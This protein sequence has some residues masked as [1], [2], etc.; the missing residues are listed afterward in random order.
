MRR[1]SSQLY[2]QICSLHEHTLLLGRKSAMERM[3]SFLMRWVPG[4]G[5]YRCP[6]L[7][8]VT[9]RADFRL[10]TSRQEIADYLGLTIETVSRALTK[11]RRRGILSISKLDNICIHDICRL[12]RMTGT[13]LS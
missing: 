1:L 4:R 2:L 9:D 8:D 10:A 6:G 13:P 7:A 11:L 12:C 5:G 3:T